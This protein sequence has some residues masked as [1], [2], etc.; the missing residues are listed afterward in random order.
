MQILSRWWQRGDKMSSLG[1]WTT[2]KA[3]RFMSSLANNWHGWVF[4]CFTCHVA[5]KKISDHHYQREG[6]E[7]FKSSQASNWH[8]WAFA[9]FTWHLA[10]LKYMLSTMRWGKS[11]G[12]T[13][14]VFK[15]AL[16]SRVGGGSN[17]KVR[18]WV[19]YNP[20]ILH[21]YFLTAPAYIASL[22]PNYFHCCE[23][24]LEF[25]VILHILRQMTMM[26]MDAS[27]SRWAASE[28]D[29]MR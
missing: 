28:N 27:M 22:G 24:S 5:S 20:C 15:Q 6:V 7:R 23:I 29:I 2:L 9:S 4:I 11:R 12:K 25:L 10:V 16:W 3:E 18:L 8:G 17:A 13:P 14:L 26:R 19:S 1:D 21:S